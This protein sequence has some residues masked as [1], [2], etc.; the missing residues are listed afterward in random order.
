MT[1]GKCSQCNSTNVYLSTEA[2]QSINLRFPDGGDL[3][4]FDCYVCLDC[5][6]TALYAKERTLS[7][8][9]KSKSLAELITGD[10]KRWRRVG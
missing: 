2:L 6:Y 4:A 3:I 7:I 10:S 5:R 1:N 8:F 9:G